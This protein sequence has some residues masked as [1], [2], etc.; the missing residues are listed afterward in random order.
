MAASVG[1]LVFTLSADLKDLQSQL[2]TM[3]GNFQSSFSKVE[4]IAKSAGSQLAGALGV[5][6][7]VGG[8]VAFAKH[9]T[10]IGDQLSDLSDQTGLSIQVLGGIKPAILRLGVSSESLGGWPDDLSLRQVFAS[11]S[12]RKAWL[13][14]S[15]FVYP[16]QPP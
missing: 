13:I 10:D 9:V 11:W 6:L 4:N 14:R 5:T 15:R 16:A 8:L 12:P 2:R 3:E 7:S 1:N